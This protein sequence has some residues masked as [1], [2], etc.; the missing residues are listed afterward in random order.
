LVNINFGAVGSQ[1]MDILLIGPQGQTAIVLS[2]A[3]GNTATRGAT[4]VLDDQ[5]TGHLPSTTALTSGNFQP[6]NFGTPDTFPHP[7]GG[8]FTPASGSALGVFNGSNPN[9]TWQLFAFDDSGNSSTGS[10]TDGWRLRIT[11]ANGVPTS[12]A[13]SFQAQAGKTLSVPA[14]GVLAND[15]DP[16]GDTLT[17]ILAGQPQKG[18][19]SLQADGS[20]T[21]KSKKTARGRDSFTYLAQDPSGLNALATVDLQSKGKKHKKGKGRK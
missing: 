19:V 13:D 4:I 17:A 3:G 21:Y 8:N 15:S 2:D 20:F 12:G 18:Q 11:S 1:D 5:A 16:D 7:S 9:G 6:T 14:M 10:I